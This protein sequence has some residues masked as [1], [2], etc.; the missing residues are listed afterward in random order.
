MAA[1]HSDP[2]HEPI[3]PLRPAPPEIIPGA[4]GRRRTMLRAI[5]RALNPIVRAL[6]GRLG[7]PLFVVVRHRGRK[8]GR[9]F[10]TPVTTRMIAGG[11]I[12][13][14]TF[15][16]GADWFQNLRAANTGAI[17]WNGVV[18][19]ITNPKIVDWATGSLAFH[20][21]ERSW[22]RLLGV[23]QFV[24]VQHAAVSAAERSD[25]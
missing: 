12:I 1:A 16:E 3:T 18:H 8:S 11:F 6:A 9:M 13:P 17:K 4:R 24:Q 23:R 25:G 14:L 7:L 19:P 21:L 20:P 15:G 2:Q 22:M 10:A 5:T